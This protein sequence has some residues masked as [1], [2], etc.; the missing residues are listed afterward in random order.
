MDN[1]KARLAYA[2]FTD[3]EKLEKNAEDLNKE[4]KEKKLIIQD[5]DMKIMIEQTSCSEGDAIKYFKKNNGNLEDA[6]IDYLESTNVLTKPVQKQFVSENDLL[7]E[8]IST[9]NKIE[10]YREILYRKDLI[11]QDKFDET[12]DFSNSTV[13]NYEYIPFTI[14]TK[15]YKKLKY[16]GNKENFSVDVLR[17]YLEINNEEQKDTTDI[18]P[19][20]KIIIK[21]VIRNG[22]NM[23][24]KWGCHK[25]VL[26]Y[27]EVD[28][29]YK[30]EQNINK[31]ATKFMLRSGHFEENQFIYGPAVIIDNWIM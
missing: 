14:D 18:I 21:T 23:A 17:P 15:E 9:V 25:P 31:L 3:V 7:N 19:D 20:K 30:T 6:I 5:D 24:R 16:K 12:N 29:K 2:M 13:G 22:L 11:F 27:L 26:A 10:T 1:D 28:E 8:D 4:E